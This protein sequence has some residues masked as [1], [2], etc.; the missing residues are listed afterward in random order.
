M[1]VAEWKLD[2][3]QFAALFPFHIAMDRE[4]TIVQLGRS[5]INCCHAVAVGNRFTDCFDILN[6]DDVDDFDSLLEN[7]KLLVVIRCR[8]TGA[9]LRGE[10]SPSDDPNVLFF[11]G[12]PW[13]AG[14]ISLK[15][16]GLTMLDFA[17]HDSTVDLLQV[18]QATKTALTETR[19]ISQ[20]LAA[21][22]K[23]LIVAR[24]LAEGANRSK[25]QFLANMSHELRTP[26]N[27][28]IGFSQM[29]G[30][31]HFGTLG[32]RQAQLQ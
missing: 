14:N 32:E 23:E 15:D 17:L 12:S 11:L 8:A 13:V 27:A 2:A 26:L 3:E 30:M 28:I 20:K 1:S 29:L 16:I 25:S 18:V 21:Q 22:K 24:D 7:R 4:M 19:V 5:I 9:K 6:P 10:V 31:E